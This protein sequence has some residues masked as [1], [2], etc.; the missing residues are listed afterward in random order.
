MYLL[1]FILLSQVEHIVLLQQNKKRFV[2]FSQQILQSDEIALFF[3]S[4]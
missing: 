1:D 3:K 2:L 4:E